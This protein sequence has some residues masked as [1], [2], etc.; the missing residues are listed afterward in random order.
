MCEMLPRLDGLSTLAPC[1]YL[2]PHPFSANFFKLFDDAPVY[3]DPAENRE[4]EGTYV[5][6]NLE[7]TQKIAKSNLSTEIFENYNSREKSLGHFQ[8]VMGKH[9]T[10]RISLVRAGGLRCFSPSH[11]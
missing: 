1:G 7:R 3:Q 6:E 11:V 9:S 2:N 4:R 8:Q 5:K 10:I